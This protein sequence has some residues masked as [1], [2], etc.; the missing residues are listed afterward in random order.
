MKDANSSERV[1]LKQFENKI[2]GK[3]MNPCE[4]ESKQ[5]LKCLSDNDYKHEMCKQFFDQYR[6][7]KKLWLEERKKANFK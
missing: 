4:K 2:P 3:Y 7:C 1:T 5:S 6:D